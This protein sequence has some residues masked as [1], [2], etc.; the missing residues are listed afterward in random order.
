MQN[1]LLSALPFVGMMSFHFF[2]AALFDWLRKKEMCS[3]TVLRKFFNTLGMFASAFSMLALGFIN[4]NN[5]IGSV[6]L[7]TLC[8]TFLEFS[9]MGGYLFSIFE[10][11]PR[12][13]SSLTALS[14]TFGLLTGFISPAVVSWLTP[15]GT[16][17]QWLLVFYLTAGINVF[18]AL[19]YLLCG[20]CT[21]LPWAAADGTNTVA[22]GGSMSRNN[23]KRIEQELKS[24]KIRLI[25]GESDLKGQTIRS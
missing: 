25:N 23:S 21:L 17:D 11:A 24:L 1:G 22:D 4:C 15:D 10:I 2:A 5:V 18:G 14:N 16:R 6:I 3:V 9:F 8:Q 20:K 13:A 12:Y 19:V 7:F